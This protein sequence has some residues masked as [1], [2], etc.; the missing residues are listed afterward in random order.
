MEE[1][2][3]KIKE[4][5]SIALFS[6]IRPDPD[7]VGSTLALKIILE[8]IGKHVDIFCAGELDSEYN[9][10]EDFKLYNK[11]ELDGHDLLVS[12]DMA[13]P[14][15]LG[16]FEEKFLA[17]GNTIKLDHHPSGTDFAKINVVKLYSAM[18]VFA[19]EIAEE[20]GVKISSEAAT[21]LYFG[22]LGDTGNF[23]Y[24][25]TDA[26][27]FE[28]SSKLM[29]YGA[30]AQLVQK[31]F[32]DKTTLAHIRLSSKALLS[33]EVAEDKFY[34]ILIASRDDYISCGAPETESIS[35]LPNM[36]LNAGFSVAVILKELS[37]GV[38][39]SFRSHES[40]DC[41]AVAAQFGGGGHRCAAG[42]KIE[43]SLEEVKNKIKNIFESYKN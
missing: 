7:T 19:Y 12:V 37:D 27:T 3:K 16:E 9:F 39:C 15:M 4:A 1:Y 17:F 22:I 38:H 29:E 21:R 5:N 2:L 6:H 13:T 8:S 41:S 30:D 34:A 14:T 26:K 10:L 20:L 43:G 23:R 18:A 35:N 32:F 25:N 28:V 24:S 36:Y 11:K 31:Q 42:C 40:F 33:A